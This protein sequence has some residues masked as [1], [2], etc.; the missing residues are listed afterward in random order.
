MAQVME[1]E[2]VILVSRHA[3]E[4]DFLTS[5]YRVPVSESVKTYSASLTATGTTQ[6]ETRPTK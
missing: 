6:E 4:K 3:A 1:S 5:V 2:S